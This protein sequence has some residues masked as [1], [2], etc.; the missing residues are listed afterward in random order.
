M[1][2]VIRYKSLD[3]TND[4]A[5]R[6]ISSDNPPEWTIIVADS[7]TKGRGKPGAGWYSPAEVGLYLSIIIKPD[8]APQDL[9]PVTKKVA[10][11]VVVTLATLATLATPAT[12]K[13]PN[14]VL[15]SGKKVCGILLE[16][17]VSGHLIIGIGLNV[18]NQP[19]SFP[20]ELKDSATSLSIE[21]SQIFD[22]EEVLQEMLRQV[23]IVL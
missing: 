18:N 20:A 12:I 17:V 5:K 10:E 22:R 19:G 4:E 15:I 7:Q 9:I 6:L 13:L 11:A 21:A 3:S 8:K 23:K 1:S 16:R 14:D 2:N